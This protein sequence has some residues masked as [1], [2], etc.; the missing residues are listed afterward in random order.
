MQI[1]R[2]ATYQSKTDEAL[3]DVGGLSAL[4]VVLEVVVLAPPRCG[5]GL[6]EPDA[7]EHDVLDPWCGLE[8]QLVDQIM[9]LHDI[10]PDIGY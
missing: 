4:H 7:R 3:L 5:I 10:H 2:I 9:L 1:I 6:D 8:V